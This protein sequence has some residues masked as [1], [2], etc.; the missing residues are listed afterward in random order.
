MILVE[1]QTV[2]HQGRLRKHA[3]GLIVCRFCSFEFSLW[4]WYPSSI[5]KFHSDHKLL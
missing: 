5:F 2:H 1:A 4:F 3:V